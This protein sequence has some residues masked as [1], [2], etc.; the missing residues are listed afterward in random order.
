MKSNDIDRQPKTPRGVTMRRIFTGDF[1]VATRVSARR[2]GASIF[3]ETPD[4]LEK[5]AIV[6]ERSIVTEAL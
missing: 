5:A 1:R 2:S 6:G 3:M 4:V